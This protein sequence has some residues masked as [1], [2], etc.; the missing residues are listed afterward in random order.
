MVFQCHTIKQCGGEQDLVRTLSD[1]LVLLA[2]DLDVGGSAVD[3][4]Q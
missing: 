2:R 3:P 4:T 1:V